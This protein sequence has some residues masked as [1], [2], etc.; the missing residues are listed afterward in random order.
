MAFIIYSLFFNALTDLIAGV[1]LMFDSSGF[2]CP[3]NP[4]YWPGKVRAIDIV[5]SK[6]QVCQTAVI[7]YAYVLITLSILILMVTS[8]LGHYERIC[9]S[10]LLGFYHYFA[11]YKGIYNEINR[12]EIAW[13]SNYHLFKSLVAFLSAMYTLWKGKQTFV[14]KINKD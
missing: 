12:P 10:M 6:G 2:M 4:D 14:Y 3:G 7:M 5:N 11:A 1:G 8:R 13:T 9:L